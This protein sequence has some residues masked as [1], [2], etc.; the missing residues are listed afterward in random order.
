MSQR[1][2][3]GLGGSAVWGGVEGH[4]SDYADHA[5]L[6]RTNEVNGAETHNDSRA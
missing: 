2:S 6:Q 1:D 5:P 4:R 3:D